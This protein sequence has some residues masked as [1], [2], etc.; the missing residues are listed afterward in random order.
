MEG[1]IIKYEA[2]VNERLTDVHTNRRD[3][4]IL[5]GSEKNCGTEA[6]LLS[7]SIDSQACVSHS[8]ANFYV[9]RSKA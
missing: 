1:E 4:S 8:A 2:R 7:N 3:K 5:E 9:D 6:E